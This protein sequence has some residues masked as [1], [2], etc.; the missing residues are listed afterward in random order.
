MS[1]LASI[2]SVEDSLED[3]SPREEYL[4][5]KSIKEMSIESDL[6]T[7]SLRKTN[8]LINLHASNISIEGSDDIIYEALTNVLG[9]DV[10]HYGFSLE[11][12]KEKDNIIVRIWKR[13]L[14]F[15]KGIGKAF[16]NLFSSTKKKKK[17]VEKKIKNKI[18]EVE[19]APSISSYRNWMSDI[20]FDITGDNIETYRRDRKTVADFLDPISKSLADNIENGLNDLKDVLKEGMEGVA[21]DGLGVLQSNCVEMLKSI[22]DF[23]SGTSVAELSAPLNLKAPGTT[24][25][26]VTNHYKKFHTF[27]DKVVKELSSTKIKKEISDIIKVEYTSEIES[28]ISSFKNRLAK[29]E[30]T[31]AEVVDYLNKVLST[32]NALSDEAFKDLSKFSLDYKKTEYTL[33]RFDKEVKTFIQA[34]NRSESD[35]YK[36]DNEVAFI[37]NIR[38]AFKEEMVGLTTLSKVMEKFYSL[39]FL[40]LESVIKQAIRLS[41]LKVDETKAG[42]YGDIILKD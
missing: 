12:N 6:L 30:T 27:L 34:A 10:R 41:G 17:K 31:K 22:P 16:S 4:L 21:N 32:L 28:S 18:D 25:K 13:I 19:A 42:Y 8:D 3:L 1:I 15:F 37:R 9:E 7:D 29:R 38:A 39:H 5:K 14:S 2:Y 35:E 24:P 23:N 20:I 40:K 11:S 36:R 26:D 33:E